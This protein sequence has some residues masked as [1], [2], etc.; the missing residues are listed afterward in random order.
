MELFGVLKGCFEAFPLLGDDMDDD[1]LIACL[2]ELERL[3]QQRQ[4]MPVDRAKVADA[5]FLEHQAAAKAA[6][7]V[8]V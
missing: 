7:A 4:I 5:K 1:R 6:A 2:G 3:D 8:A